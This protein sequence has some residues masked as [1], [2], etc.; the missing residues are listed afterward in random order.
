MGSLGAALYERTDMSDFR[1]PGSQEV[2]IKIDSAGDEIDMYGISGA[3]IFMI[4][5]L[6]GLLDHIDNKLNIIEV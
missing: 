2:A 6:L 5:A 3:P 1:I 4:P